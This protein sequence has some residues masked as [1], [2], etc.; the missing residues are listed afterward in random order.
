MAGF[1]YRVARR[2]SRQQRR[3][4][5]AV[6]ALANE[7]ASRSRSAYVEHSDR[8]KAGRGVKQSLDLGRLFVVVPRRTVGTPLWFPVNPSRCGNCRK[9]V[10]VSSQISRRVGVSLSSHLLDARV[11]N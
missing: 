6:F 7:A 10:V 2:H 1:P 11:S 3:R 8:A 5:A 9:S 4:G